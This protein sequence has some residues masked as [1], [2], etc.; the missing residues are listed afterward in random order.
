LAPAL[1]PGRRTVSEAP[2]IVDGPG[3]CHRTPDHSEAAS[4]DLGQRLKRAGWVLVAAGILAGLAALFRLEVLRLA[5]AAIAVI[6]V[7]AGASL[8]RG[9]PSAALWVRTL[10]V[11]LLAAS[12][13]VAVAA[14]LYQPLDLTFTE[15][16]L[17]PGAFGTAAVLA[18]AVLGLLLWVS[19]ELGRPSIQ[20]AL[21]SARIRRWDMRLPAEAGVGVVVLAG[22]LLWLMLHGQSAELATSLALQQLGPAYRYHLSW[23][24]NS[25]SSHGH[26]VTGVVTAWKH[27]EVKTVLLHWESP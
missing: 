24:S 26:S 15:I 9:G 27:D 11:F 19:V 18:A 2:L 13:T 1:R 14:P 4:L 16:R 8:L 7:P 12:M 5:P 25:H 23:I 10:A 21:A 3:N 20:D 22:L 17:N 6:A